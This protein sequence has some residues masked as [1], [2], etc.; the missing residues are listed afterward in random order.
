MVMG[1]MCLVADLAVLAGSLATIFGVSWYQNKKKGKRIRKSTEEEKE[2]HK[3]KI[4]TEQI[5]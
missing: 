3:E 4:L 2:S 1:A 5:D